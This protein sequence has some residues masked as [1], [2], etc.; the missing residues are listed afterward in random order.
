MNVV[1]PCV[2]GHHE[3]DTVTLADTLDFRS[4]I[5]VRNSAALV[6]ANDPGNGAE[7]L[8]A[9]TEAYL[10]Y[11]ITAWTLRDE[12]GKPLEPSRSNI[13]ER[14]LTHLT[15]A[16]TVATAA[17]DVYQAVVLPLILGVAESSPTGPTE[18]STSVTTRSRTK[19]PK[20]SSPS[21]TTSTP[22]D[23]T[24]TTSPLLAG[25]SNT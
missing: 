2:C 18:P 19:R 3:T 24:A 12:K 7:M 21:S 14:L 10:I 5:A 4:A 17:D 22:T 11:G 16:A 15:E 13:R 1:I 6:L 9:L 25:G 23:G 20:P 8:A